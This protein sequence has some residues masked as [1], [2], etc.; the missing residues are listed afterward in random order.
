[1]VMIRATTRVR[2]NIMQ[3]IGYEEIITQLSQRTTAM[4]QQSLISKDS[5]SQSLPLDSYGMG[6]TNSLSGLSVMT[7]H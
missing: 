3:S 5:L 2:N 4:N 6:H 7:R 1:M